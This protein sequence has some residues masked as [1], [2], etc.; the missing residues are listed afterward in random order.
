ME[1]PQISD[2]VA[3]RGKGRNTVA[4]VSQENRTAHIQVGAPFLPITRLQ[5]V[6]IFFNIPKRIGPIELTPLNV[7]GKGNLSGGK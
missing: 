6:M 3:V 7:W 2:R 5:H 4:C 1:R